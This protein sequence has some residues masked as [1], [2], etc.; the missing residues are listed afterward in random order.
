MEG[1]QCTGHMEEWQI[2]RIIQ[3]MEKKSFPSPYPNI[4][5]EDV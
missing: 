3:R 2:M 5:W 1:V 4:F